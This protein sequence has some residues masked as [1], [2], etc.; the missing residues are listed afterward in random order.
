MLMSTI[1]LW[2]VMRLSGFFNEAANTKRTQKTR[3][4]QLVQ[5]AREV[6]QHNRKAFTC[7][8]VALLLLGTVGDAFGRAS[9]P[10]TTHW[11]FQ[12]FSFLGFNQEIN[13]TDVPHQGAS[14]DNNLVGYWNF[15]EGQGAVAHD[16]SSYGNNGALSGSPLPSWVAG[17]F[18]DA[19]SFNGSISQYV[20]TP[21]SLPRSGALTVSMWVNLPQLAN[22][23]DTFIG[24][25]SLYYQ[26]KSN[27]YFYV[28]DNDY[29][30]VSLPTNT[31]CNL[32]LVI[33]DITNDASSVMYV[34]GVVNSIIQQGGE[35]VSHAFFMSTSFLIGEYN[36][37]SLYF[38]GIIDDVRV[39]NRTLSVAEVAALFIMGPLPD[40]GSF[41]N[42]YSY[43]DSV[44]NN[45]M[46]I[47]VNSAN[48]SV[49]NVSLVTCINFFAGNRLTFQANNSATVNVWTNLG[50]PVFTTG[51]WNSQNY[52]T[53]LT[54]NDA[55]TAELSW[56]TYNIITY[57]D[58]HS[59]VSPS[60]VT[61]SYGG[62]Q[63]LNFTATHGYTFTVEV[64]GNP[65]GQ[66][67]SYTFNN[68]TAPHTVNVTSLLT[69]IISTSADLGSTIS[70]SGDVLVNYGSSQFFNIQNKTGYIVKHIY[71][72]SVD[73][74]ALSNFTFSN[75][76]AN[77]VISVSSESLP[78]PTSPSPSLTPTAT[79]SSTPA[80]S[81]SPGQTYSPTPTSTAQSENNQFPIQT[82][83]IVADV[84]A[85]LVFL[86]AL[87]F[88]KGYI[89]IEVE[90]KD[91]PRE[92]QDDYSI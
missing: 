27:N 77:H 18:G 12:N 86:F 71:V 61:V 72:D 30:S 75:V 14:N 10:T 9:Y 17:K 48:A 82:V 33:P 8:M 5:G 69:Y 56:N 80:P 47:H 31:W 52:T 57:T 49:N 24:F 58:A 28:N 21:Y 73:K 39:Y 23:L 19:I 88:K 3:K 44:T 7:L 60:N 92:D 13:F 51:V 45:T 2:R 41:A 83:A 59:T 50:E 67:S 42:Y 37:F 64:D 25:N 16:S 35:E 36:R 74:G 79:S 63:T 91:N 87:A 46:L 53:T 65:K 70:P 66:I 85:V 68:V 15:N 76:T 90:D 84:V 40:I 1:L 43:T 4:Y 34:D 38:N 32:I 54:L 62:S 20:S 81:Q 78:A 26:Q 89:K 11:S 29:F 55:S 22:T 6:P